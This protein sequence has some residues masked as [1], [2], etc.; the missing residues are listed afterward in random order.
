MT[1]VSKPDNTCKIEFKTIFNIWNYSTFSD[2]VLKEYLYK[3]HRYSH[4]ETKDLK[5]HIPYVNLCE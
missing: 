3:S 2:L 4:K 1:D 5:L